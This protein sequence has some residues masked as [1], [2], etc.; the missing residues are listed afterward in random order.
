MED[1]GLDR[2]M[3]DGGQKGTCL[4]A[5]GMRLSVSRLSCDGSVV[6][7]RQSMWMFEGNGIT[8]PCALRGCCGMGG[9][10]SRHPVR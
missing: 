10:E 9:V 8:L 6:L 5:V 2:I 4:F 1:A 7:R 3:A